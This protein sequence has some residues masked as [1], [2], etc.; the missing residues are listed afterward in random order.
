MVAQKTKQ[1]ITLCQKV[2]TISQR[3]NTFK[4]WRD[5]ALQILCGV[6]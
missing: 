5:P 2:Q 1:L 4:V 3:S 6:L